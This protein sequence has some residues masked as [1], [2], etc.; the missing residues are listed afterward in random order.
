M[1]TSHL[2]TFDSIEQKY[3]V[4]PEKHSEYLNTLMQASSGES[5]STRALTQP[6]ATRTLVLSVLGYMSCSSTML[7]INKAAVKTIPA[8]ATLL[9]LQMLFSAGFVKFLGMA[10]VFPVDALQWKK[11]RQYCVASLGFLV[12]L[13]ANMK[14]LEHSNVETFIVCTLPLPLPL[15]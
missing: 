3:K 9:M 15:P 4:D 13:Y 11:I 2:T 8:P 12:A 1:A 5:Y 6:A 10:N 7:V 14:A